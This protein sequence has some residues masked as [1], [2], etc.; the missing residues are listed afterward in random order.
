MSEHPDWPSAF[1]ATGVILGEPR[2]ASAAILGD[3]GTPQSA[4]LARE[5]LA[6]AR[7]A[8]ARAAARVVTAV[9]AAIDAARLA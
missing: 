3:A 8:R 7:E 6:P 1:L 9:A 4:A 5:L 2:D